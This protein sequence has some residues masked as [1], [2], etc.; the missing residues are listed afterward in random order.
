[1]EPFDTA[2]APVTVAA[3]GMRL[4][5]EALAAMID[6][7]GHL[8]VQG[9]AGTALETQTAIRDLQSDVVIVDV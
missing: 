2:R 8:R 7:Q 1:M 3:V 5:R 6:V 4:Y 9:T